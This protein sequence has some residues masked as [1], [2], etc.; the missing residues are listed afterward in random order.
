MSVLTLCD[1]SWDHSERI[2]G[3]ADLSTCCWYIM[4]L[5]RN[6]ATYCWHSALTQ[7]RITRNGIRNQCWRIQCAPNSKIA[8]KQQGC[9]PY[10][11][12]RPENQLSSGTDRHV[13]NTVA[14]DWKSSVNVARTWSFSRVKHLS[15]VLSDMCGI[16][17][18]LDGKSRIPVA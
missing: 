12:K 15:K 6:Y 16:P 7:K 8:S 13:N 11:P 10:T 18:F 5:R 2:G 17:N 9:D 14:E 4:L 3:I 1:N